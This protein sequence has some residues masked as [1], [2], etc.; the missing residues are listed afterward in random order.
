MSRV[1]GFSWMA[2]LLVIGACSGRSVRNGG[3]DETGGG[4]GA[5]SSGGTAA[6]T[7]GTSAGRAPAGGTSAG[8]TSTGGSG[9]VVRPGCEPQDAIGVGA[10]EIGLGVFFRG[11]SCAFVSGCRCEGDDCNAAYTS[12]EQCIQANRGCVLGCDPQNATIVGSCEPLARVVFTGVACV[13]MMG[14]DCIGDDCDSTYAVPTLDP[15]PPVVMC[16]LAH[17]NCPAAPRSCA[18][19]ADIYAT[20]ASRNACQRDSD[21]HVAPGHCGI[22]IGPCYAVMN[23]Q[24]PVEGLDALAAEWQNAGCSAPVCDCA[25]PPTVVQCLD[26][27]CVGSP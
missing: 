22:G 20:Y 8:G 1:R 7:G 12:E 25:S 9:G 10:C 27:V 23:A 19:I 11:A 14:C 6:P 26:G 21:C 3:D 18:E 16:E 24:W 17:A 5:P 2:V 4:A 13:E 15:A